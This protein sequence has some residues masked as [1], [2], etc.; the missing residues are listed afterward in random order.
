[1]GEAYLDVAKNKDCPFIIRTNYMDVNV[2][3][4]E[5]NVSAY[6]DESTQSVVLVSGAVS[7]NNKVRENAHN[8]S[9]NQ[10]FSY[11]TISNGID[12]RKVDVNNYISWIHGY[13]LLDSE[14]LNLVLQKLERHFNISFIY[15]AKD[16]ENIFVSGKL[17]L[18]GTPENV[19]KYICIAAPVSYRVDNGVIKIE[20]IAKK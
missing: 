7:V 4:T 5:L 17:D 1:M 10:M 3:G 20:L 13:L 6:Q 12:V 8:I 9:P 18:S 19:L 2:L 15:N 14:S 16:F 11:S